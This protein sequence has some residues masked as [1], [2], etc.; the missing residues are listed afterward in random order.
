MKKLEVLLICSLI[1]TALFGDIISKN[2]SYERVKIKQQAEK[3]SDKGCYK[4]IEIDGNSQ[5]DA[6]KDDLNISIKNRNDCKKIVIYKSIKN[7]HTR[8]ANGGKLFDIDIGTTIEKNDRINLKSITNIENSS[9]KNGYGRSSS[10]IGVSI[11][12]SHGHITHLNGVKI[13]NQINVEN[14]HI[15]SN[16]LDKVIMKVIEEE[17]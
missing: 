2:S 11:G 12:N 5:W 3:H 13:E 15:G 1:N 6:K 4:Y 9:I 14:S 10:N 8:S 17:R 7:V 16:P